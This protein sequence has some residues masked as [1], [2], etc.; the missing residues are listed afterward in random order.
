MLYINSVWV[1]LV[2]VGAVLSEEHTDHGPRVP[3]E[4]VDGT[5]NTAYDHEAVLGVYVCVCVQ[6]CM[7]SVWKNAL[8]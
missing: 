2:L 1:A 7:W 3:H 8:M 6:V 4:N 5:H